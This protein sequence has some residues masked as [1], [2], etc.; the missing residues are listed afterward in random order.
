MDEESSEAKP[1][2]PFIFKKFTRK[3]VARKRA[4]SEEKGTFSPICN[5]L[6]QN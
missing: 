1:N 4:D 6:A 2:V 5:L 3:T